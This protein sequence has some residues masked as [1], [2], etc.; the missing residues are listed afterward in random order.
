MSPTNDEY[1][2]DGVYA[3]V[4]D[5]PYIWLAVNDH[6]NRVIALEPEVLANLVRYARRVWPHIPKE[7]YLK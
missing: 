5:G 6:R 4:D 7:A 2:G 3:S 1:L